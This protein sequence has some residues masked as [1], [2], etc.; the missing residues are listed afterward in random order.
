V[1]NLKELQLRWWK[2]WQIW[3]LLVSYLK[4]DFSYRSTLKRCYSLLLLSFSLVEEKFKWWRF[5]YIMDNMWIE[6]LFTKLDV[7]NGSISLNKDQPE[8]LFALGLKLLKRNAVSHTWMK[9]NAGSGYFWL[10]T[11]MTALPVAMAAPRSVTMES[12]GFLS[13]R[14][15]PTTPRASWK[16]KAEPDCVYTVDEEWF[17]S[18]DRRDGTWVINDR[19]Q[20]LRYVLVFSSS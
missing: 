13:G 14:T 17:A 10:G 7:T 8:F 18:V 16:E 11:M 19:A 6:I 5:I 15:T 9:A 20:H 2:T 4:I 3:P 12:R 1:T